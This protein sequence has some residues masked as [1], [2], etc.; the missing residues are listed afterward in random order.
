MPSSLYIHI[1]FCKKICTYCDFPKVLYAPSWAFSYIES[2]LEDLK[3]HDGP[4]QTIYIGGG[5][6]TALGLPLLRKLLSALEKKLAPNGEFS[7]EG[8]PDSLSE[9]VLDCLL[10]HKINRLSLGAQ[11]SNG[12]FLSYLGRTHTFE[13]V[14]KA[15]SLA[16]RKG[17]ENINVDMMYGFEGETKEDI[18]KDI[19]A[20]LSLNVPHL[21][22]YS[23]QVEEGTILY[24][25]KAKQDDDLAASLYEI[26]VPAL[27]KAG[28]RRYEVSNF[29]RPSYECKHNLTYWKD[30][31]YDAIG[32]G[33]S[34]Y[35]NGRRY[36]YTRNLT[37]YLRDKTLEYEEVVSKEDDIKYYLT[38]NLRLADGFALD[39]FKA[40]FGFAF[41]ERYSKEIKQAEKEGLLTIFGGNCKAS[42]KG[43]YLLDRILLLFY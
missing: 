28:Y 23:L 15:V 41:E 18:E 7:I 43:L 21:S 4:Y 12:R 6:P 1:P 42:G 33:A 8:N 36:T 20:F 19:E 25:K 22:A 35:T 39:A 17:M 30:E 29:C 24:R 13:D 16:K 37:R 10:S 32:L 38:T 27:E 14:R 5:T 40:R 2:L 26:I 34:G 31:E 3:D 9:E 11:T